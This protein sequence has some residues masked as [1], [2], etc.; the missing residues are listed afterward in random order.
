MIS[1]CNT[2]ERAL[3]DTWEFCF[4]NGNLIYKFRNKPEQMILMYDRFEKCYLFL[5][6]PDQPSVAGLLKE[7]RLKYVQVCII[8]ITHNVV[9]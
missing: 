2:T 3:F 4:M 6:I 9:V 1:V 7:F 8:S 5:M